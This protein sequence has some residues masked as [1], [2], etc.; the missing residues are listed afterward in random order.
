VTRIEGKRPS[1]YVWGPCCLKFQEQVCKMQG[2]LGWKIDRDKD[3]R[4]E[5]WTH[6]ASKVVGAGT[7]LGKDRPGES[8]GEEAHSDI[9]LRWVSTRG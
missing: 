4:Y 7:K 8:G 2:S 9:G 5:P 3:C 6:Y 1:V